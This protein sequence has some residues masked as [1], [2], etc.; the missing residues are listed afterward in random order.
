MG[1]RVKKNE[2]QDINKT[3]FRTAPMQNFRSELK[4]TLPVAREETKAH[5]DVKLLEPNRKLARQVTLGSFQ[6]RPDYISRAHAT[7]L[8]EY[9]LEKPFYMMEKS[10]KVT[11]PLVSQLL[12]L[13]ENYID[14]Y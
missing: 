10:R 5:I 4:Q 9:H 14:S 13:K 3:V 11:F 6:I 7:G 1:T 8:A 12:L 2:A